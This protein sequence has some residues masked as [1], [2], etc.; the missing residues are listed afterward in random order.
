MSQIDI[1]TPQNVVI[2]FPLAGLGLRLL[3][4]FIDLILLAAYFFVMTRFTGGWLLSNFSGMEALAV[5]LLLSLPAVTYSL[6]TES[7]LN[8]R[9]L[10][11]YLLKLKVVKTNGYAPDF[12]DFFIRW[13][14][15][16]VDI[17][18]VTPLPG[19][20]SIIFSRYDQRLGDMVAG[21]TVVRIPALSAESLPVSENKTYRPVFPSVIL[22][23]DKDMEIIRRQ[24]HRA[25]RTGNSRV[26]NSLR[27]KIEEVIQHRAPEMND[28]RFIAQIIRDY[29]FITS[30]MDGME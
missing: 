17:W 26:L 12:L 25:T 9:T 13:S 29:T 1:N 23:S 21:T 6:W 24:Y 5:F 18:L 14:F 8:G 11:K 3:A 30:E 4:A 15:R 10:G 20:L 2:E 16:L 28:E 27:R 7:L 22:L 19:I